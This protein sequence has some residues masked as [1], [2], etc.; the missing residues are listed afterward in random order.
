MFHT[1]LVSKSSTLYAIPLNSN[2]SFY[3]FRVNLLSKTSRITADSCFQSYRFSRRP[4]MPFS[5]YYSV[6][7]TKLR[8]EQTYFNH[9]SLS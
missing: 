1:L 2:N 9:N 8:F 3:D 7:T 6:I 5:R 4:T